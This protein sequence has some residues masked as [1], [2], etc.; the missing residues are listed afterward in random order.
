MLADVYTTGVPFEAYETKAILVRN[1]IPVDAYFNFIYQPYRDID[2]TITGITVLATEV[3]EHVLAK[4]QI[5]ESENRFRTFAESIQSLAWIANGNGWI[6]WYNQRWYDYTGTT[7]EEMQ[8]W[9][10]DKVHHPD[11]IEKIVEF[12]KEAWKK[13]ESFELTFPLRRHDGQYRWFLT[14]AYPVKDANGNIERWIGTNTDITEQ[15][16][17]T[18]ELET[19]VKER[20]EELQLK[21]LELENSNAELETF[22]Y[23]ASHDLQEPLRKIQS[24]SKRILE[25]EKFSDKTQD[26]FNRIIAA[27]ERM[28][29][30][31]ISLLSF[32]RTNTTDL[33]LTPCDLNTI[34]EESKNDL[35]LKILE[36]HVIIEY[37]KLPT[38]NGVYVLIAQLFT[39]L[40]EN[41]I[42]YSRPEIKP[43]IKITAEL[44]HGN[45]I[46]HPSINKL[47]EYHVLKIADNGIGFE[48]QYENKIF[49]LFQRLHDNNEYSGTGIGLSICKK[50]VNNH[51]GFIIAVG[52]PNIG[53]T[54]TIYIPKS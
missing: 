42:K 31:I 23:V 48:A 37:E 7:L 3:T 43:H 14:R 30:L 28:Q 32:S 33:I 49:G 5:E 24:F 45:E 22:S 6:Y 26:Y 35:I 29:N 38:I 44:I 17:F 8:G 15:K 13:D 53:S 19:K 46:R 34:V 47:K 41:A 10:W 16:R 40:I 51:N 36:K 12:V 20:T 27:S 52:K 11:Y 2:D 21:N 54:F 50:I 9:G 18:E 1:G 39:N 25:N 4:K